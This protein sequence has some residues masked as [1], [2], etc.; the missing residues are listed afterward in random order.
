V[1]AVAIAAP[2]HAHTPVC[3]HVSWASYCGRKPVWRRQLSTDGQLGPDSR[4]DPQAAVWQLER[5][6][7]DLI[8][9]LRD[10][11][12][13]FGDGR[14]PYD[15]SVYAWECACWP[16]ELERASP[17][18]P[19]QAQR[20]VDRLWKKYAA[21]LRPYFHASPVVHVLADAGGAGAA[22]ANTLRHSIS[23]EQSVCRPAWLAHELMHLFHVHEQHGPGWAAGMVELWEREFDIPRARSLELA[24]RHGVEVN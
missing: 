21:S 22:R 16:P 19:V 24:A 8:D 2:G 1:S 12:R 10:R 23:I 11:T 5:R 13:Q 15:Q 17:F 4:P 9:T 7:P 18:G 20:Y 6:Y 3:R 14:Q